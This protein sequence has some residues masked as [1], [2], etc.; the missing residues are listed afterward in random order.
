MSEKSQGRK[1]PVNK[2][3]PFS[4]V[5]GPGNRTAVFLQG[6][7][8][9]CHYCHNPETRNLCKNCGECVE[10]CPKHALYIENGVVCFRPE[11]CCA[12][13]TCIKTCQYGCSPRIRYLDA[14]EVFEEIQKQEPYIRGVTVSGGECTLYPEFLE[15]LFSL[16]R[17][18][19]LTTLIDSNGTLDFEQYPE[20]LEQTDGVMLDIKAWDCEDH[21][22]VTDAENNRILKNLEY[23]AQQGKLCEVRTVIV[24]ELFDCRQ[25]VERTAALAAKYMDRGEIRYKIIKYRPMG[26]REEYAHYRVPENALLE[27]LAG[28][29]AGCG[30]KDIVIV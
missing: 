22:R 10:K 4:A 5:D 29:A 15:E 27:E 30:M 28:V 6:C 7:N 23:L 24:P 8:I 3:I 19:K 14:Q 25:T 1:V 17:K 11:L 21:L 18:A 16:C 20:L 26:V 12:C 2:I 13:D 9:N